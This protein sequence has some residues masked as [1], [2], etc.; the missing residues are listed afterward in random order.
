MGT[1]NN[2]HEK[3]HL[4]HDKLLFLSHT[5]CNYSPWEISTTSS[6]KQGLQG[7]PG[8]CQCQQL[9]ALKQQRELQGCRNPALP[10]AAAGAKSVGASC[11]FIAFR[12]ALL[13]RC[14]RGWKVISLC[15]PFRVPR[16]PVW[17]NTKKW[18]QGGLHITPHAQTCLIDNLEFRWSDLDSISYELKIKGGGKTKIVCTFYLVIHL[19]EVKLGKYAEFSSGLW[20]Y[21][22]FIHFAFG[23]FPTLQH[24][25]QDRQQIRADKKKWLRIFLASCHFCTW[26][27]I[28]RRIC[29]WAHFSVLKE[30]HVSAGTLFFSPF[31]PRIRIRKLRSQL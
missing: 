3:K 9:C 5:C 17:V 8:C 28:N 10:G 14:L 31:L 2:S 29:K 19:S 25:A 4:P 21:C 24:P 18:W 30:T 11:E 16:S 12:F 13:S 15:L 1:L 6:A 20:K 27:L 7:L 26:T 23:L 22:I